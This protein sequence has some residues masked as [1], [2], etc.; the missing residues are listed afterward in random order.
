MKT[1]VPSS[2]GTDCFNGDGLVWADEGGIVANDIGV[3]IVNNK[4]CYWTGNPDNSMMGVKSLNDGQWHYV[5]ATRN[6]TAGTKNLYVDGVLENSG[7]TNTNYLAS[8]LTL[9]IAGNDYDKHYF[10]GVMDQITI[11]N[12]SVE[13]GTQIQQ[14]YLLASSWLNMS[15][16]SCSDPTC[17]GGT[18]PWV[19]MAGPG[20]LNLSANQYFQYKFSMST[21]SL[22]LLPQLYN[23]SV[24]NT[25]R[26]NE[27]AWS[28]TMAQ[29]GSL[30]KRVNDSISYFG[31]Y[32]DSNGVALG[33]IANC[34]ANYNVP[35]G[36]Y[37][38]LTWTGEMPMIYNSST[39]LYKD[40]E[41]WSF[42]G[43][44]T[45]L[46]TC[47]RPCYQ[48][49]V[50]N[51]TFEV[52]PAA[53]PFITF[54]KTSYPNCGFMYYRVGATYE[55]GSGADTNVTIT[56][57]DSNGATQSTSNL[58]AGNGGVGIYNGN[59][60]LP[61]NTALGNWFINVATCGAFKSWPFTVGG[62]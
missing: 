58:T 7:P 9:S 33:P 42:T 12:T 56:M 5:V 1:S 17:S 11:W 32:T 39:G 18:Q 44:Y 2:T 23:V 46:V 14:D 55:N 28:D 13:S 43:N 24:T 16:R 37:G 3:S 59:Y 19:P 52:D 4:I 38:S 6:M 60:T 53:S 54:D 29:G 20:L 35:I 49:Q 51:G 45:F 36:T 41:S 8:N 31:N 34:T 48:S 50:A 57:V 47:A 30:I 62:P 61:Y 21:N 25:A 15:V 26:T 22:S 40:V 27:S 10:N